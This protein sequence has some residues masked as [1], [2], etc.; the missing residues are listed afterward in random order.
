MQRED[1][2]SLVILK[3][4]FPN[5]VRGL[6]TII[7]DWETDRRKFIFHSDRLIRLLVE[8]ALEFLPVSPRVVTTPLGVKYKG[9]RFDGKIC[10]VPILRAGLSMERAFREVCD[11]IR[12][13]HVLVQRDEETALPVYVYDKFPRDIKDRYVLVLDP[14]LA[15]GGSVISTIEVLLKNGVS[16]KRSFL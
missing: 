1:F 8:S 10:A 15:T 7:R 16:Q 2:L 13:G 11:K 3:E 14:M 6:L 4:I 5:Q 9:V 12:I